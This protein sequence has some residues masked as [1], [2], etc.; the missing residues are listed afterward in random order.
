[1]AVRG[2]HHNHIDT[3]LD[4]GRHTLFRVR[5]NA[6]RSANAQPSMPIFARLG[7]FAGF[8]NVFHRDQTAQFK[9]IVHH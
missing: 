1:M 9:F 3:C 5:A 6:N 2:I 7:V 8:L 4:Q